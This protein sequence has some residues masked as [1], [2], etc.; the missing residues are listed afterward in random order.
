LP[1]DRVDEPHL[2]TGSAERMRA[3]VWSM[4]DNKF[5]KQP[6]LGLKLCCPRTG[7]LHA[8]EDQIS[9][10]GRGSTSET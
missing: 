7:G 8:G 5:L 1:V 6:G 9:T 10:S 3:L 4:L 2:I